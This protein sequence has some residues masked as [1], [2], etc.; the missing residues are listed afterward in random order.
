MSQIGEMFGVTGSCIEDINKGR[1]RTQ[2]NIDY[3]I[4][5]NAKSFAKSG[6][7]HSRTTLTNAIVMEIRQRYITETLD[8][9]YLDYQDLIGFSGFKKICYGAT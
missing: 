5:K 8:Q 4:R 3:P 7:N 1:T 2:T 9:I 6:E